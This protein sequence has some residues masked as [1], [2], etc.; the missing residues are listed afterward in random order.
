MD[1]LRSSK[2]KVWSRQGRSVAKEGRRVHERTMLKREPA[3]RSLHRRGRSA[4]FPGRGKLRLAGSR[5]SGNHLIASGVAFGRMIVDRIS[6]GACD[7]AAGEQLRIPFRREYSLASP[8]ALS[9]LSY[10]LPGS[11]AAPE[12]DGV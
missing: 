7:V 12:R 10:G 2:R 11:G 6:P 8:R 3:K 5:F 1:V 4:S 9:Q